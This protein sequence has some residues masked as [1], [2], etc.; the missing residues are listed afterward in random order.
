MMKTKYLVLA[1][2]VAATLSIPAMAANNFVGAAYGN[3]QNNYDVGGG[4]SKNVN[5]PTHQLRAGTYINEEARLYLTY[6]FNDDDFAKQ[7]MGLV[8]YDFLIPVSSDQKLNWFVGATA[9]VNHISPDTPYL[10][11][12][13]RFVWGGQT[14]LQY[15]L[16][17]KLSTE[18]GY[19]YLKQDYS[20]GAFSFDN[21]QQVYLGVDY[22]F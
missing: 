1:S 15:K 3:Q 19:R 14:G 8:S 12:V 20:E 16:D 22:R 18:V 5:D 7:Q 17:S 13:N 6:S 10:N 11:S 4:Y 2:V 21:S 9:G